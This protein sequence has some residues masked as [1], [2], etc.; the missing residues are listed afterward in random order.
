MTATNWPPDRRRLA[1][2]AFLTSIL[3]AAGAA[4][5]SGFDA[6][7]RFAVAY[8]AIVVIALFSPGLIMAQVIGG[9]V[10]AGAVLLAPSRPAPLLLLPVIAGV[11][12]TA[13]LLASAARLDAPLHRQTRPD[14][15][16]AG[17]AALLGAGVFGIV[18]LAGR[19]RG[20]TGT[21]ATVLAAAA[22][23]VLA[24]LLLGGGDSS[25]EAS[26]P[27][28]RWGSRRMTRGSRATRPRSRQ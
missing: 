24:F 5:L 28:L 8:V 27:G 18:V 9:Q 26:I 10:L 14:I 20:L 2:L 11:I 21:T 4:G 1:A 23:L 3:T 19:L 15:R 17:L 22:F 7:G 16:T 6:V 13:E 25:G 12:A